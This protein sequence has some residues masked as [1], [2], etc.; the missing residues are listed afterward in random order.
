[1]KTLFKQTYGLLS[2]GERRQGFWLFVLILFAAVLEML[3]VASIMPFLG[4]LANPQMVETQPVLKQV[5][6]LG[7]FTDVNSFMV[8]IGVAVFLLL[9]LSNFTAGLLHWA[10]ARFTFMRTH[11]IS[12][13]L[14][15]IYLRQPYSF[16]L[17]H[18][19]ADMANAVHSEVAHVVKHILV[20]GMQLLSKIMV[21]LFLVGLLI[22]VNPSLALYVGGGFAL[23]YA[24]L[25]FAMNRKLTQIGQVR[26]EMAERKFREFKEIFAAHKEIRLA[27]ARAHFM[28][29]FDDASRKSAQSFADYDTMSTVPKYV[30]EVLAY[31]GGI[32]ALL[33]M[34]LQEQDLGTIL[35]TVG[36]YALAGQ[37]L[38][39]AMQGIFLNISRIRYAQ[40]GLES[41]SGHLSMPLCETQ[42]ERGASISFQR[43][44]VFKDASFSYVGKDGEISEVFKGLNINIPKGK[45]VGFVGTTGAGK[46][47]LMDVL[48]GL[49][50][51]SGGEMRVD[52]QVITPQD[53][54]AW[55]A[56]ISYVPQ[57]IVLLNDTI[58]S[59]VAFGVELSQI[60]QE[61]ALSCL[62]AAQLGAFLRSELPQGAMSMV[63]ENGVRLS[64]GQRQR[65]GLARALYRQA[66]ILILD[67]A[68]SALD[69][70]TE[71]AV[72]AEIMK[73]AP[74]VDRTIIM[75]AHR[76]STVKNCDIIFY[77][78]RGQIIA[79]GDF[80]ALYRDCEGFRNLVRV[81]EQ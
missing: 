49:L 52:D 73:S 60:D 11:S 62:E 44:I 31:G 50:P 17:L 41:L 33:I 64:G 9:L 32:L 37:R 6:L 21:T 24:G 76:L 69:N 7:H 2:A 28:R 51:L 80:A 47:T 38:M 58:L 63:G 8:A 79:S 29:G 14:M 1:M 4:V 42:G 15:N 68:T 22:Y 59:N 5:Y 34:L 30:I 55:Q 40:S 71:Q 25:Y 66:D 48:M 65:I 13:R 36:V 72:I 39:P 54:S 19:T 67:E 45:V 35:P 10:L 53:V 75:I 18:D 43:E 56:H 16:F 27:G 26:L 46:S 77:M 57:R 12:V 70:I 78:D 20:A 61:R 3:G 81:A 23:A 74:E